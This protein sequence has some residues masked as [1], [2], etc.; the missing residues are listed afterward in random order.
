MKKVI[1]LLALL[2]AAAFA[3][4]KGS[5][6]DYRDKKTYKTVQIGEQTWMAENLNFS[7][8][9]I[10][11]G[12]CYNNKP[13]FCRKYG[14]LYDLEDALD[15]CPSGWSLPSKEDWDI[16]LNFIDGNEYAGT[17]LKAKSG[18]NSW[19]D[20]GKTT[21]GNGTDE[22]GFAA[23]PG[24]SGDW[25]SN[26]DHSGRHGYWWSTS[27]N[28]ANLPIGLYMNSDVETAY[29]DYDYNKMDLHSIRCVK[30]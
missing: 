7:G 15:A 24:G 10:K 4:K 13:E 9:S 2:S 16:L 11:N 22:F 26:F 1:V 5:F 12:A 28:S 6:T 20:Y 29:V 25:G 14:M 19:D 21:S 27:K 30:N 3:Q 8:K 17:K 23:L 18:W